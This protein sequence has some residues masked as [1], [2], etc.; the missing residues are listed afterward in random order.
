MAEKHDN[1]RPADAGTVSL[2]KRG[3]LNYFPIEKGEG[4][5][6]AM[7]LFLWEKTDGTLAATIDTRFLG[8]IG[9]VDE[10]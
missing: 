2:T 6:P 10:S 5:K 3:T 1:T 8:E 7:A 9:E 4:L